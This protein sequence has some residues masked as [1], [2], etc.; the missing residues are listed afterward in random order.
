MCGCTG[1]LSVNFFACF[2]SHFRCFFLFFFVL[3]FLVCLKTEFHSL[4][5]SMFAFGTIMIW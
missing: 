1:W 3:F 2:R 4:C 5:T